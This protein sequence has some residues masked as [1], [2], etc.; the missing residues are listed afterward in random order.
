MIFLPQP[1]ILP[2]AVFASAPVEQDQPRRSRTP[3][4]GVNVG[5]FIPA[6]G[7]LRAAYG[8]SWFSFGPGIG[9]V[10]A[11]GGFRLTPELKFLRSTKGNG[12]I[13]YVGP[14][15]RY[16]LIQPL[17]TADSRTQYAAIGPYIGASAGL[18]YADLP[19]NA[20]GFGLKKASPGG[21][22]F[23][24]FTFGGRGMLEARYFLAPDVDGASLNGLQLSA[25]IRF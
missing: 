25:G 15:F 8:D 6:S 22:I 3:F 4:Y 17:K 21:S 24:G 13:A 14:S 23:A 16:N 19:R 20:F 11:R 5:T 1:I 18:T 10:F 7:R 2:D 9:P 12:F